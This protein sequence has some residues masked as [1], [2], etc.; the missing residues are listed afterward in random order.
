[1]IHLADL[2]NAERSAL[3]TLSRLSEGQSYI[4]AFETGARVLADLSR[5]GL[6]Q[7]PHDDEGEGYRLTTQG[8][9][10]AEGL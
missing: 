6:A 2:S 5:K 1:M 9:A 10:L 8:A 4:P 3:G 7:R